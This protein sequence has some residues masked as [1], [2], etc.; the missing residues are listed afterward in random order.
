MP[1]VAFLCISDV[2]TWT[3]RVKASDL[4]FAAG[5]QDDDA[6]GEHGKASET[7]GRYCYS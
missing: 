3:R 6:N 4:L 2:I 1:G 7:D 5:K